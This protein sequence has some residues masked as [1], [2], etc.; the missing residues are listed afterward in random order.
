[1]TRFH[2]NKQE[3]QGYLQILFK[4]E[5]RQLR[6]RL[7]LLST[8]PTCLSP[9]SWKGRRTEGKCNKAQLFHYGVLVLI[10]VLVLSRRLR[11]EREGGE[12]WVFDSAPLV[13]REG[14]WR[15]RTEIRPCVG[16]NTSLVS[17]D[18]SGTFGR[19]LHNDLT[20]RIWWFFVSPV[21]PQS[22]VS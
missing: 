11:L 14:W 17:L 13:S 6:W 7:L 22:L 4:Y 18:F 1:M 10:F 20:T 3:K 19:F 16:Q 9:L 12:E 21:P 15:R 2:Y 5:K 8:D